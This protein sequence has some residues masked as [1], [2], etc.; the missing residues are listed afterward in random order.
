MSA[1]VWPGP[2]EGSYSTGYPVSRLQCAAECSSMESCYGFTWRA[3]EEQA[4]RC[5][6]HTSQTDGEATMSYRKCSAH[7][8]AMYSAATSSS[9]CA[10]A[11]I[12][13]GYSECVDGYW[14]RTPE[15]WKE[16]FEAVGTC[17]S[18]ALDDTG[19]A[20]EDG[21]GSCEWPQWSTFSDGSIISCASTQSST[22]KKLFCPCTSES[23]PITCGD[24]P[25]A[26]F[27]FSHHGDFHP[28]SAVL[29]E[30][31]GSAGACGTHCLASSGCVGFSYHPGSTT[32]TGYAWTAKLKAPSVAF[33]RCGV[34]GRPAARYTRTTG[35]EQCNGTKSAVITKPECERAA[36]QLAMTFSNS[37]T[38]V[39]DDPTGCMIQSDT[40][41]KD[42]LVSN[43]GKTCCASNCT[44]CGDSS[45]EE[46]PH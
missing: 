16:V 36:E 2:P 30:V 15:A 8:W 21:S 3:L 33:A 39:S 4:T 5:F 10:D 28:D 37:I 6:L 29:V 22:T 13:E 20:G 9:T 18:Y 46:E 11:C 23:N 24:T 19:A 45:C 42:G 31:A 25:L 44:S 12:A 27:E 7:V 34:N 40:Y 14:P 43:D 1:S 41:C 17:S 35:L 32:C 38:A 26:G